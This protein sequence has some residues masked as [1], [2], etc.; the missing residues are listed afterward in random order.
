MAGEGKTRGKAQDG[1]SRQGELNRAYQQRT[2]H[3]RRMEASYMQACLRLCNDIIGKQK[4]WEKARTPSPRIPQ[5][6]LPLLS[7]TLLI[8]H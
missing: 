3:I 4:L 6:P 8:S 1:E 2:E 5:H 7:R